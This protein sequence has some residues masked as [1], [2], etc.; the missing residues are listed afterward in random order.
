MF[1]LN[2]K[3][4]IILQLLLDSFLISIGFTIAFLLRLDGLDFIF[5]TNFLLS[6]VLIN[7]ITLVTFIYFGLYRTVI[8]FISG[9]FFIKKLTLSV[10]VS[11]LSIY[12]FSF[13][14]D[15]ILPRSIPIIYFLILLTLIGGSRLL[16]K[17]IHFSMNNHVRDSIVIYGAGQKGR[18]ILNSIIYS[19][20]FKPIFFI[21]D[22]K[23]LQNTNVYGIPVYSLHYGKKL[24]KK[25]NIKNIVL[26]FDLTSKFR[27]NIFAELDNLPI[28]VILIDNVKDIINKTLNLKDLKKISIDELLYRHKVKPINSLIKKNINN[29]NVLVTGGAGSIGSQ[30]CREIIKMKPK[31]IICFDNSEYGL[32]KINK[33]LNSQMKKNKHHINLITML[34]SIH[35]KNCLINLFK[36]HQID[37]LYHSAAYKHVHLVENNIIEGIKNNVIGTYNLADIAVKFGVAN[38][39]LIST[40]KAVNPSNYMGKSK[41]ISEYICKYFSKKQKFSKFT[42]VR[43]GNVLGSSGSVIPIFNEQIS[44]GGPVT[45][46]D[47]DTTRYFMTIDEAAQLVIQAGAISNGGKTYILDMGKPIKILELAK[48]MINLRGLS[49]YFENDKNVGDIKIKFV[50]L[51]KGEKLH[52]ELYDSIK[53]K[54]TFHSKIYQIDD[55]DIKLHEFKK[56]IEKINKCCEKNDIIKLKSLLSDYK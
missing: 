5:Y 34:G 22:D 50:G 13:V 25:F 7:L 18:M 49:S 24:F 15:I 27:Q 17:E 45:V 23:N 28:Q 29:K 2:R 39:I 35:D 37:T 3:V 38:F 10:F 26:S 54:K 40:D 44:K 53:P 4:K 21:D 41:R 6:L 47:K 16:L 20:Q 9:N 43:F 55:I 8:R 1:S 42:S 11:S 52:E 48:K 30:I 14:L 19:P 33:E 32:F 31:K 51:Q 12:L 36:N 56:F 46:T